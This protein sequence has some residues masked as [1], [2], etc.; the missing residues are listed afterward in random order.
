MTERSAKFGTGLALSLW[1]FAPGVGA[2]VSTGELLREALSG[3]LTRLDEIIKHQEVLLPSI[4]AKATGAAS[5]REKRMAMLLLCRIG[6]E[7]PALVFSSNRMDILSRE[8]SVA[9]DGFVVR[10]IANFL[11]MAADYGLL[12]N[13]KMIRRR[14]KKGFLRTRDP[15]LGYLLLRLVPN[16]DEVRNTVRTG[17][18]SLHER[19]RRALLAAAGDE[20]SLLELVERL[21]LD[22][23]SRDRRLHYRRSIAIDALRK[24]QDCRTIGPLIDF[25]SRNLPFPPSQGD[26][27]RGPLS[28]IAVPALQDIM[29]AYPD[30]IVPEKIPKTKEAFLDWWRRKGRKTAG[31]DIRKSSREVWQKKFPVRQRKR[32]PRPKETRV[33]KPA[34][35]SPIR[36]YASFV[37]DWNRRADALAV[38]DGK[39]NALEF[40]R[41]TEELIRPYSSQIGAAY[42]ALMGGKGPASP[43][44]GSPVDRLVQENQKV[45]ALI[46]E[47]LGQE[48]CELP[49]LLDVREPLV[50]LG[51]MVALGRLL[52]LEGKALENGGMWQQAQRS[53]LDLVRFSRHLA[54]ERLGVGAAAGLGFEKTGYGAIR[55]ILSERRLSKEDY[56]WLCSEL[57]ALGDTNVSVFATVLEQANLLR[58]SLE[59]MNMKEVVDEV[60]KGG[61]SEPPDIARLHKEDVLTD[62]DAYEAALREWLDLPYSEAR[63]YRELLPQ[64]WMSKN[65]LPRVGA[66]RIMRLKAVCEG[67][68]TLLLA[69]LLLHEITAGAFPDG[70][71]ALVPLDLKEL[72]LD[73]FTE[74]PFI[75]LK[76]GPGCLVYSYGPDGDDDKAARDVSA[77]RH[78]PEPADGDFVYHL[79]LQAEPAAQGTSRWP[80]YV[81]LPSLAA[82]LVGLTVAIRARI[83]RSSPGH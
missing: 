39:K 29:A 30:I 57:A 13:P 38:K 19:L 63:R 31:L 66:L 36:S 50:F 64:H 62:L 71:D 46:R 18:E 2:G 72:P 81:G 61:A 3:N 20:A 73:P 24:A 35:K 53:Y 65:S 45:L 76:N 5:L 68:A 48:R 44:D 67:R 83:R 32:P 78:W 49:R 75:Y 21:E 70:L 37:E 10:S 55:G 14:V 47:G 6:N 58:R 42:A 54:S 15:H 52:M 28:H 9:K 41:K 22:N 26:V 1:L 23:R 16:D 17:A 34:T 56:A 60:M 80:M 11:K 12:E 4:D 51:A 27:K 77:A 59:R 43:T 82:I 69:A 7:A 25:L 33:E 74:K 40:Y 8:L 79:A